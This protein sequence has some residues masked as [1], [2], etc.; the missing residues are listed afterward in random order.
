MK[1]RRP[2]QIGLAA[3]V[4]S[5]I[6]R[7]WLSTSQYDYIC[8]DPPGD[9]RTRPSGGIYLFW[10]EALLFPAANFG[11]MGFAVLVSK[12][13]DGELIARILKMLG[14][15]SVRGSTTRQSL[16]ALRGLMREIHTSLLAIT[17]DGPKGPRRVVQQGAIY[18]ASKTGMPIYPAGF[19]F[20]DCWRAGSWDRMMIPKPFTRG[21]G[22]MSKGIFVPPDLS[23]EGIEE[24]R[25]LVQ[26][27]M[28]RVQARAEAAASLP[29]AVWLAQSEQANHQVEGAR[30]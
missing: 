17:P 11:R 15:A 8:D 20:R 7:S 2:W 18:V 6:I 30:G 13:R 27:A 4:L 29:R 14:I 16:S 3:L 21:V 24:H 26:A 22:I 19:A 1:L 10:H 25:Q 28:D 12:H 5:G 9:P 23:A